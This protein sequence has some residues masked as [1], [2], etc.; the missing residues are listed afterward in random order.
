M[1][2]MGGSLGSMSA[3]ELK[4][5]IYGLTIVLFLRFEPDGLM[6]IYREYKNRWVNWPFR[7]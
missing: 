2:L 4:G 5:F 7:Y 3:L 1:N 6:G